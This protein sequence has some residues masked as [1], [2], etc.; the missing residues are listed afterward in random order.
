MIVV[1]LIIHALLAVAPLG[2]ITCAR[3]LAAAFKFIR[4]PASRKAVVKTIVETT[5]SSAAVAE[6]TLKL[7]FEPERKV[8]PRRG[9]IE[10]DGMTQVIAFMGEAGNLKAPLPPAERFV[11]L[12]YLRAA[13]VQ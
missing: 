7:F 9:E 12:T 4:D 11:D 8:L 2:A 3:A 6:Q 10:V 1:L 13:G 5:D